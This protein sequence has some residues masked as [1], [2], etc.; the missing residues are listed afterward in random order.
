M[1]EKY[2]LKYLEAEELASLL[3]LI[4]NVLPSPG[5]GRSPSASPVRVS[6]PSMGGAMPMPIPGGAPTSSGDA[7]GGGG[8]G[9]PPS[10]SGSS[11]PPGQQV[12]IWPDKTF[13]R[14]IVFAP[15]SKHPEVQRLI[16]TLD[17]EKPQ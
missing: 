6:M 7:G 16:E 1:L 17:T 15:Q 3:G 8:G 4:L 11:P 12:R 14:L 13:N 5:G 9:S 10:S 2:P